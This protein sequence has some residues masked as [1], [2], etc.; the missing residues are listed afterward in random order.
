MGENK[1]NNWIDIKKTAPPEN[2]PVLFQE[3]FSD[4]Y[5]VGY[6]SEEENAMLE[7]PDGK[8]GYKW[9]VRKWEKIK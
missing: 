7:F 6:W 2:V 9:T 5:H 3:L 8:D 1:M 4:D